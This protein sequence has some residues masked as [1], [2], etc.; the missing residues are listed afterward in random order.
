MS[1][2]SNYLENALVDHLLRGQLLSNTSP[3]SLYVGLFTVAPADAGGGT[4]V[5]GNNYGRVAIARSLAAW[6]GTQSAGSTVVSSGTGGVTSNNAAITFPTPSGT[7]GTVT[8]F[9]IFD[10]VSG[11]NL[12]FWGAL[13]VAQTINSGNGVSYPIGQLQL[14]FA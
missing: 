8:H 9:G 12:W 2:M 14:T 7:W 1:A 11:G 5:T 6:A 13:S 3:A 10:A 4:E